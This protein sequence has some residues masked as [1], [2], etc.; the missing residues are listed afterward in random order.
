MMSDVLRINKAC[1]YY[2]C[3][4]GLEDCTFCWCPFY[5]CK[6]EERGKYVRTKKG[7][8]VWDCSGCNWIHQK[9]VVDRIFEIIKQKF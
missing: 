9:D 6:D 4:L 1:E 7:Q 5:P 2:P 8:R 3:H